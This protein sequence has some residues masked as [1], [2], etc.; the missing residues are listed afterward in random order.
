MEDMAEMAWTAWTAS[1]RLVSNAECRLPDVGEPLKKTYPSCSVTN[2][3][4]R[5]L[6]RIG[7]EKLRH[8]HVT[9]RGPPRLTPFWS[10]VSPE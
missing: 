8:Y 5:A 9:S 6:Q 2:T 1:C 10:H 4:Q 7:L 3:L